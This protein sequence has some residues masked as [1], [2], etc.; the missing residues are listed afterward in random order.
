MHS[1]FAIIVGAIHKLHFFAR[2]TNPLR[3]P[4]YGTYLWKETD[5]H[6]ALPAGAGESRRFTAGA[7]GSARTAALICTA[8]LRRPWGLSSG[9]PRAK[10]CLSAVQR[11]RARAS[12]PFPAVFPSLMRAGKKPRSANVRKKPACARWMCTTCARSPILTN[13]RAL[14]TRP[15]TC[16]LPPACRKISC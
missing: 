6:S 10:C 15:A 8:M 11:N 7:S 2:L 12:L 14:S 3:L 16:F 9:M 4:Y 5:F 13:T 1:R